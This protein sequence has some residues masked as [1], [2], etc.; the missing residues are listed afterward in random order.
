MAAS[1][2]PERLSIMVGVLAVIVATLPRYITGGD[3][4]RLTL[5]L[6][7]FAVVA[8]V[9]VASWRMLT[10]RAR[11]RVPGLL[12]RL[13]LML[14]LGGVL[15]ALWQVFSGGLSSLWLL[16]SHGATLGL[17]LHALTV[18]WQRRNT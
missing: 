13:V 2:T 11:R 15:I 4:G 8:I 5:I 1:M 16:L 6:L 3:Q 14:L 18:G 12:G 7:A 9:A 17:L 10:H